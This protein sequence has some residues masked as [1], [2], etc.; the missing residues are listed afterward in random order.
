MLYPNDVTQS[1][2]AHQHY[3]CEVN[4][5][6]IDVYTIS[7][8]LGKE[9]RVYDEDTKD[10]Y[11][12]IDANEFAEYGLTT[13]SF[14]D[15]TKQYHISIDDTIDLSQLNIR[16]VKEDLKIRINKRIEKK[17]AENVHKVYNISA[18]EFKKYNKKVVK[19]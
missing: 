6:Y 11:E 15:C 4:I 16:E 2:Q 10:N 14:V 12:I 13:P 9:K 7:S 8:I 17:K 1:V 3:L 19:K 18:S 5:N